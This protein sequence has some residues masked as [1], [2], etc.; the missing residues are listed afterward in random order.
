MAKL[1]NLAT[2]KPSEFLRQ[3]NK[4]RKSV[5]KWLNITD[6]MNIRKRQPKLTDD[7][8]DEQ[9]KE[10]VSK[11]T[12]EN[13][14]AILDSILDE[15]PDETLELLALASFVDPKD[16]DKHSVKEYMESFT[17]LMNDEDVLSFFTS[18][19]ELGQ[20]LGSEV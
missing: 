6:I 9:K 20:R 3:T 15:H 18:L 14:D 10:A 11:Q 1:K 12:R 13:F 8:T 4:I 19:I 2:C 5:A 17:E 7:M 16:V